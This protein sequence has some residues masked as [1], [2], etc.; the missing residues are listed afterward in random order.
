MIELK[1]TG[2]LFFYA[3]MIMGD[4]VDNYGGIR[5]MG[6]S[7]AYSVLNDIKSGKRMHKAVLNLYK[8]RYGTEPFDFKTWTG[9]TIEVTYMDMFVEQ[10]RLAWMQ[11]ER[12]Q[13]WMPSHALPD[14]R[15]WRTK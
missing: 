13:K 10:G 12:G 6:P 7:K 15:L 9:E 5:G 14:P 8:Q 4:T 1:G 11:Q 2:K 3:Q